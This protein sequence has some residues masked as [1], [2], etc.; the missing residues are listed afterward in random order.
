MLCAAAVPYVPGLPGQF[1]Y[2]DHRLIVENDGLRRP[3]D[4]RRAILRDYYA[5]DLDRKGLGYYRPL[6]ILSNELD[7]RRGGGAPRAFHV[8]NIALHAASSLLVL[9]LGL[10]LFHG[11]VPWACGA[12]VLFAV[13]PAHAES[14]AF[15]SG[16]VDPLATLWA[17]ASIVLHLHANRA[18]R[19]WPWRAAAAV[20]WLGALLCKEMAVTVPVLTL[21]VECAE[22]GLPS[23]RTL[24]PR[25]ARYVAYAPTLAAYLGMRFAALGAHL[26][27]GAAEASVSLFRPIVVAGSHLVW[28]F[29]PPPGLHLEPPPFE[30]ALAAGAT[31][32][33]VA[34]AAGVAVAWI[35]GLRLQAALLAWCLV[36]LLPVVQLRPL[37]TV[38][39]ERF[40]YLPTVG[41][42]LLTVSLAQRTA[43]S[44]ARRGLVVGLVVLGATYTAILVPRAWMWR[45]EV[46]LWS[47]KA[48]EEPASI[49]AHLNLA[50]AFARR[51]WSDAARV[52]CERAVALGFDET[53]AR[54]HLAGLLAEGTLEERVG[55]V[56]EALSKAPGDG[57]LWNNLGFLLLQS[58]RGREAVAAFTTAVSITPARGEAWLGLARARASQGDGF[59]AREAA[60]HASLLNPS[61]G[62]AR[63]IWAV[64]E[65]GE[66]R[67]CEALRLTA[68]LELEEPEEVAWLGR[69]R[70]A[71]GEQCREQ[72]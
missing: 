26:P 5:S 17:L 42:V 49:K 72:P 51:G 27:E 8:T 34:A 19:P 64:G 7:S 52:E 12:A 24:R 41:A 18:A 9:V 16:R 54:G 36:S 44:P 65:L 6:A 23:R 2:D 35:R 15:I 29:L 63:L 10:R 4:L 3:F 57:A 20:A 61:L 38:L 13:H 22:E 71:A 60:R 25:I 32:V 43:R 14:V 59:G 58:G 55:T 48:R 30:G 11:A 66:G 68:G 1:V 40:L 21:A 28:T 37:E 67:P 56:R 39:S 47:A 31:L 45:D 69:L 33:V 50:E 46:R 53:A 62:L 70:T